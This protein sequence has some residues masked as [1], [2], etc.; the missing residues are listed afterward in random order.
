MNFKE[1]SYILLE[2]KKQAEQLVQQ[3]KL[4]FHDFQSILTIDPTSIKKFTGWMA[5]Q[6][7]L[8][9]IN[10]IDKLRNTIE[11]YNTFLNKGK[12]KQKD[13][14]QFK[15]FNDLKQVID[16]LNQSGEG[17][18]IGELEKNYEIV[19]DDEDLYVVVPHTHEASRKLGLSQFAFRDCGEG[20]DSAWCTTYKAPDHFN[21]YYFINNVTFYYIKV[22]SQKL[23]EQL[24]KQGYGP[25]YTIVA[26]AVLP[27][28]L[29]QKAKRKGY[30]DMDM[31]AYDGRDKQF[32]GLK[33]QKYLEIIGLK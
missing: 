32:T 15:T 27:E 23:I 4:S 1:Y 11:E 26:I 18:S 16:K 29:A 21:D 30:S 10:N 7:A 24:K 9:Q 19:R 3:G 14:Y 2:N 12:I 31:D 5:K 20:K 13:I 28:D 17:I 22:K 6:W 8:G 25:Q 33:L